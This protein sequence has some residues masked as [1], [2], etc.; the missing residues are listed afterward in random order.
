MISNVILSICIPTYNRAEYLEETILSIVNQKRFQET[1]DVEIVISDNC[2]EDSTELVSRKYIE[3]YS[4]KIRYHKNSINIAEGNI[5]KALSLGDGLFLKLNND[6][7]VHRADSLDLIIGTIKQSQDN[8]DTVFFTNGKVK[9]ISQFIC[10]N[11]DSFVNTVSFYSTWIACF[12]IWK[13]DLQ[14]LDN[15]ETVEKF[16]LI[17]DVLFKFI[18]SRQSVLVDNR[19]IFDP[20]SPKYKGGYN[21]YQV[22]VTNYLGILKEYRFKNHITSATLFREKKKLLIHY[23]IPS[24]LIN[25]RR[26]GQ[27]SFGSER[28]LRII[29]AEYK[30]HPFLYIGLGYFLIKVLWIWIKIIT[31]TYSWK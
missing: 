31:K 1:D 5:K 16:K 28:A 25:W 2:S 27:Y 7:L 20:I 12:G 21:L 13:K 29:F 14:Y 22:F 8:N 6:T 9:N 23:L 24:T 3:I 18:I 10:K 30:F 17:N 4:T 26:K 15:F 11:L 19:V